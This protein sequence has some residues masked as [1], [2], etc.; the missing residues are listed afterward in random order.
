MSLETLVDLRPREQILDGAREVY[1]GA[2]IVM[3]R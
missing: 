1:V 2:V 3:K